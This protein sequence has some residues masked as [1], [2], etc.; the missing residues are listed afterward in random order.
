M[1][2]FIELKNLGPTPLSLP[3]F[4][5]TRGISFVFS[6]TNPITVL[7]PDGYLVLVRDLAA[8]Q[9][10]YPDVTNIAGVFS[11]ALDNT[12]ETLRLQGPVGETVWELTY[13]DAWHPATDGAGFSLVPFAEGIAMQ[14]AAACRASASLLGSP[15]CADPPPPMRPLVLVNEVMAHTDLPEVDTVELHNPTAQAVDLSGWFLTDAQDQPRKYP[16]P[17]GTVLP[18]FSHLVLTEC[19]FGFG[20]SALGEEVWLFSGEGTHLTGYAHGFQFGASFNGTTLGRLV[21]STGREHL[22]EQITPSLGA[23][24]PGPRIGPVIINELMY[25]PPSQ[26]L[27]H[28]TLHE[29]IE[30]RNL[31]NETVLLFDPNHPTNT[32]QLQDV[33]FSFPA[34]ISLPPRGYLLLVT[35]DPVRDP[36]ALAAFRS[37]YNLSPDVPLL[38]PVPGCLANEGERLELLRPDSPQSMADPYV[39]YVPYVQV[40]QVDYQPGVPWPGGACGTGHSLQR[41]VGISFSNDPA[42]W[43]VAP[44]TPGAL[45]YT[46]AQTDAD[47]DGLPDVWETENGLNPAVAADDDGPLGD[48]DEDGLT[49][50]QEYLAGT[51]PRNAASLLRLVLQ[52]VQAND[53]TVSFEAAPGR[54]YTL[55]GAEDLTGTWQRVADVPA[56]PA[57][58]LVT[59]VDEMGGT[60]T[61]LYRVITPALP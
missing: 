44:P 32:W 33:G 34:G 55:L 54:S 37:R 56:D 59:L 4:S 23:A 22:V 9:T 41:R 8:F 35:F 52:S 51:H 53:V 13:D 61:R 2:E 48:P 36:V 57:L 10:R 11:G 1:F 40:E 25:Q 6:Y 29:F 31:S 50:R 46:A 38:G 12:G 24:N 45:N 7:P 26:P 42:N 15:G 49:N 27:Y 30:L 19:E 28:D 3:G 39:G 43:E 20:L 58:R 60:T 18:A 47:E 17:S 16:L 21:D 14:G 5:F